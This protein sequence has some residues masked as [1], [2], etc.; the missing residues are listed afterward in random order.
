MGLLQTGWLA[1]ELDSVEDEIE[2]W[3]VGLRDSFHSTLS[4]S[5]LESPPQEL[6]ED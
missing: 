6:Q 2:A 5:K 4:R 3:S 1:I